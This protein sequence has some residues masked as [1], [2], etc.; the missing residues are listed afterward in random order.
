MLLHCCTAVFLIFWTLSKKMYIGIYTCK[1]MYIGIQK[2]LQS[3]FPLSSIFC[4]L[5]ILKKKKKPLGKKLWFQLPAVRGFL[6]VGFL[7]WGV[8]GVGFLVGEVEQI[9]IV[10]WFGILTLKKIL[11]TTLFL[12]FHTN[13]VNWLITENFKLIW[14]KV[15][16]FYICIAVMTALDKGYLLFLVLQKKSCRKKEK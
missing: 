15:D 4:L 2:L 8:F 7:C 11:L 16:N 13:W 9:G 6:R 5:Q 3:L 14:K 10:S 12:H 1:K